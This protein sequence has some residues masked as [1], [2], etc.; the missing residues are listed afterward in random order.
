MGQMAKWLAGIAPERRIPAFADEPYWQWRGRQTAARSAGPN[1]ILFVD[2]FKNYLRPQTAIAA[3]RVL[4][5]AGF[6]VITPQRPL[7]CGRPRFDWGMLDSAKSQLKE[8]LD[9]VGPESEKGTPF[10]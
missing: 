4:G 10:I 3:T 5:G 7:C 9:Q 1:V 2:T 8:I 6:R